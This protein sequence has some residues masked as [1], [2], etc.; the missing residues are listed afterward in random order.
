[1]NRPK[2][3]VAKRTIVGKKVKKLRRENLLPANIY[4]KNIASVAVQVPLKEFSGIFKEAGETGLIDL[5]LDGET[6]PVL[7]HNIQLDHMTRLPLHADFY[8]VNLKEKV[9]TMVPIVTTG[10]AQAVVD[11]VGLLLQPLA[12]IE[13]EALPEKLPENIEVDVTKLSA[14]DDQIT[15]KELKL[16]DGVTLLTDPEQVVVKIAELVTKEA[17]KQAA[18]EATAAETAKATSDVAKAETG[19]GEES[20]PATTEEA[21]EPS[22]PSQPEEIKE[23]KKQ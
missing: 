6:R 23:A 2:L 1:M 4:G 7:I 17:Q 12:E 21:K 8:Q 20:Q 9:K 13:V 19:E 14:V 10:E 22:Q 5:N 11:K 3:S 18:A 15:V 16:P